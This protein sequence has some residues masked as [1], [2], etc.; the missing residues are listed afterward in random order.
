[1]NAYHA[2]EGFCAR[3][4]PNGTAWFRPMLEK[5]ILTAWKTCGAHLRLTEAARRISGS[6]CH[7]GRAPVYSAPFPGVGSLVVRPCLHGGWWGRVAKD[8]YPGPDRA[9]REIRAS[10]RLARMKIP[11]PTV[12]AVLFY[13]TGPF[14][15]IEV[16]TRLIPKSRDLVQRMA[17]RPGPAER[18][19]IFSAVRRLFGQLHRQGVRHSDLNARNILLSGSGSYTA[20]LLDVDAVRFEAPSNTAVD[21][22]NRNRLLRSLLKRARLGDLGWAETEVSKLWR[23]LFPRR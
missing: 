4:L 22:A 14:V 1:M 3:S 18:K 21:T 6:Q 19:H 23:E 9:L 5:P 2:P 10:V 13:P 17:N 16:V 8:L 12:E 7:A 11:T 15:R 20:W